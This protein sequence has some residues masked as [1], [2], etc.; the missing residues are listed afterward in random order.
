MK[1]IVA[2]VQAKDSSR[3]RKAFTAASI[4]VTQLSTT[5]GFLREGNATFLIGIQDDRVQD[6]LNVIKKNAKSREQ[7]ITSQMHMDVE[8]GSAFPVNVKVG[9]ATVF[10]LPVDDF[11]KF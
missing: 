7:Y 10:V 1:M 11:I 4:Q 8:G 2:I 5:G 9:G 3:L 6:V